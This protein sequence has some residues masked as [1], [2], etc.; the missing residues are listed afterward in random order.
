[1]NREGPATEILRHQAL[2]TIANRALLILGAAL[3]LCP[4]ADAQIVA[5]ASSVTGR[6]LLSSGNGAPAATLVTGY[7]LGP[8]DRVDTHGGG[9][10]VIELTDG[11]MIV[12]QP[13]SVI[14]IK[15]FRA[16]ASLRELFEIMLGS[17]RVKINHFGGRPNPY[18][19]NSPTASI[20]VRGTDFSI[21]VNSQGDTKVMVYEGSV[22]VT[23]LADPAQSVVIEADRGV[24]L[25][26]GQGFQLFNIPSAHEIAEQNRG[27]GAAGTDAHGD[28][29]TWD[30][31]RNIASI[32]EQYIAGL[33]EIGQAPFLLRYNAF[34]E[35]HLDSLENPAYATGFKAAEGRIV[36][37]PSLN[38]SGG[39][40]E[41]PTPPGLSSFSPLNYSAAT[42][43][44]MFVPLANNFV[45]GG[46]V[47]G[48]K[49]G[50]GVQ[51]APSDLGLSSVLSQSVPARS[52]QTS[53]SSTGEFF[54][55]SLL[56]ARRFGANTSVGIEVESLRGTGSLAAQILST[57]QPSGSIERINSGSSISQNRITAGIER[58][59]PH[60]QKLAIFYRYS[61]IDAQDN[62]ASH[63]LNNLPEPL[64]STRS[65][66]HS[67][68]FGLRL[69]GPLSRRFFYGVE[70]SWLGLALSDTLTRSIAV[71]SHQR[72]RAQRSS[73]AL[74]FG[75]F[76]NQR[77]V[78]SADLAGGVSRASTGRSETGTGDLL[79]TGIQNSRFVSANLGVQTKL[80]SHLF[81]NASLLAIGQ[82]YDLNQATYPD[83]LGNTILI[84][85][86]FLPLTATGYRLP[87]R[88]SDFGAG[89][90]FSNNLFAQYVFSTSYGV[91]SVGHTFMLR[92]T[93]RLHGE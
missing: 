2:A 16:A 70:A 64:D 93:F 3:V 34:P 82:A 61:L 81:L 28:E 18:R 75:Y 1:L 72:D 78:L 37:L 39:L 53:G 59:L 66:G 9:R 41:N 45:I 5:R 74:G 21:T 92:Y 43:F 89:W 15:D 87:R 14:V 25:V 23:N 68:E 60:D 69:R 58:D 88:S 27:A 35:S 79:Q 20:A 12:V 51:G 91:D 63:S 11:S 24:L 6:V 40:D 31:P 90:R 56:A 77:T 38:G 36:F 47:T 62:D 71:D 55:G 46:S 76:L 10:L 52:L 54:S 65:S 42:Q 8:G 19:I 29:R 84:T 32:Y 73:A 86:P 67:S 13:E 4:A 50:E 44:S 80:S 26:P 22:E 85:D 17:V 33:S 7:D 57:G 49:I 83:S 48:S 30:S